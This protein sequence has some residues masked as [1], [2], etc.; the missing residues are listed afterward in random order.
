MNDSITLRRT[1]RET[2]QAAPARKWTVKALHAFLRGSGFPEITETDVNAA[3]MW[4]Q[5]RGH[6]NY[7]ADDETGQEEWT[8]TDK[9]RAAE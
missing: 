7:K 4:N 3:V 9:G 8:L 5:S 2:M 1:V 6:M